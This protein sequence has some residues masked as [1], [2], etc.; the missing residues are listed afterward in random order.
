MSW[1]TPLLWR[2]STL[3]E[4][5][6]RRIHS[7]GERSC[8][9]CPAYARST[10][11]LSASKLQ[12]TIYLPASQCSPSPPCL[13][14]LH[15]QQPLESHWPHSIIYLRHTFQHIAHPLL[16]QHTCMHVCTHSNL[17]SVLLCGSF[18]LLRWTCENE[19]LPYTHFHIFFPLHP[20]PPLCCFAFGMCR[21]HSWS[22][23]NYEISLIYHTIEV[24]LLL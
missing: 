19:K 15:K 23:G 16:T 14:C 18:Y 24:S 3:K 11:P 12:R 8:W 4:T 20:F 2:Q 1:R 21:F 9:R 7:T 17:E 10:P 6:Y 22:G 5:L 13:S